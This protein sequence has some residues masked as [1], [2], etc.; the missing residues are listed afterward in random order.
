MDL[1]P[2]IEEAWQDFRRSLARKDRSARTVGIYRRSLEEFWTWAEKA[3]LPP[4]PGAVTTKD[5]NRW[6]DHMLEEPAVR[7]GRPILDPDTGQPRP[8]SGNTIRIRW[9]NLRPFFSWYAKEM[10]L[11]NPFDNADTPGLTDQPVPV[12]SLDDIR[13]LLHAAEGTG[14]EERRDQA[15]IR[16]LVDTGARLGEVVSM[17]T[18]SWDRRS[19]VVTLVGKTGTR[20]EPLSASVGEALARYVRLRR[21][22]PHAGLAAFWLGARGPLRDSGVQQVL[23]RRSREAGIARIHPHQLRH[24]W[25]HQL[26][27]A[28]ASE[29]D[30]MALGGWSTT[31][32]VHRY[33]KSAAVAR[34]H[35]AAKRIALGDKL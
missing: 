15:M 1:H 3:G 26:K 17:T 8:V 23:A 2:N 10:E 28:G 16:F 32:M 34:A 19:D 7:N 24:T 33:G 14:F 12:V 9:Q 20:T 5:V 27:V 22:R 11:G 13:A 30:L 29:S 4:D 35:D 6:V 31:T 18:T 21:Q 25:A